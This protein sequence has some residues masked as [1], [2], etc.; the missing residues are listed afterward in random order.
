MKIELNNIIFKYNKLS[1]IFYEITKIFSKIKNINY[2]MYII[3]KKIGYIIKYL[4]IISGKK[5]KKT[6]Y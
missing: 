1:K 5:I 2:L 4:Q 6:F 3:K